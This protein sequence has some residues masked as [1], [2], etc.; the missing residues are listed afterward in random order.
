MIID[1][2]AIELYE[3]YARVVGSSKETT[4]VQCCIC[5][6]WIP[7]SEATA[8]GFFDDRTIDHGIICESQP[9]CFRRSNA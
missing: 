6:F 4:R 5:K 9:D 1:V 8:T 2:D 7:F 3:A